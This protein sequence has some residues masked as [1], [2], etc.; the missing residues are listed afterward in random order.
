MAVNCSTEKKSVIK[1]FDEQD[2]FILK[3]RSRQWGTTLWPKRFKRIMSMNYWKKL[4]F[5]KSEIPLP[6]DIDAG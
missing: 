4:R 1:W 2:L 5:Y 6:S 3:E